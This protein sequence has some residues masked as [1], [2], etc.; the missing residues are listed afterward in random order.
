MKIFSKL[1]PN[2]FKAD[3][4]QQSSKIS[5]SKVSFEVSQYIKNYKFFKNAKQCK[6]RWFNHLNPFLNKSLTYKL[7]HFNI[8]I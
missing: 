8:I 3:I 1:Y 7:E 2:F 4:H 5:W 6:E